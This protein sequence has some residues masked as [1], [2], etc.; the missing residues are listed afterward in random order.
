MRRKTAR[1]KNVTDHFEDL[2]LRHCEVKRMV[3]VDIKRFEKVRQFAKK[4]ASMIFFKHTPAFR[5]A[6]LDLEDVESI[7]DVFCLTYLGTNSIQIE[8]ERSKK[9]LAKLN[10][11]DPEE[12]ESKDIALMRLQIRQRLL[13]TVNVC[14]RKGKNF[15]GTEF[16][17][18]HFRGTGWAP[19]FSDEFLNNPGKYGYELISEPV[20]SQE[21]RKSKGRGG[22][23]ESNG[24]QYVRVGKSPDLTEKADK[25][26]IGQVCLDESEI[27][28]S[29]FS[30]K[31][32]QERVEV[33][34]K[35]A[36]KNR[37][38]FELRNEVRVA[39]TIVRKSKQT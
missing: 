10:T 7:A 15:Y 39:K 21:K 9:V 5:F 13:N 38:N 33:I 28:R 22:S 24:I 8:S 17:Q 26:N 35:F 31:T 6:G 34:K 1:T 20:F 3:P 14:L 19:F 36:F 2:V 30:Q 4:D 29:I 12:I 18:K 11:D 16:K 32:E 25:Y 27:D 23:F 37:D